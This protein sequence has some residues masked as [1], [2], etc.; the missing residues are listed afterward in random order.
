MKE[1]TLSGRQA[2]LYGLLFAMPVLL[3]AAVPYIFIWSEANGWQDRLHSIIHLNEANI[4]WAID[5]KWL[6]F[7]LLLAG[8]ALHEL[9]HGV[10]MAALARGGWKSVSFGFNVKA[11]APYAHC[12]EALTPCAYRLSLAMPGLLLGDLPVLISWYTGN[13]LFLFFGI[14]FC[15]AASGDMIILW[16]SRNITDGMLQDHPDKIGFIHLEDRISFE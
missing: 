16:L 3:S 1:Y 2:N 7:L 10:C 5:V 4:Q 14:L 8:T 15:W 11:I 13:L 9:I 6:L 12:R